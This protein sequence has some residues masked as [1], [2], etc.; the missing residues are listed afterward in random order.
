MRQPNYRLGWYIPNQVAGLTHIHADVTAEDF[1]AVV[2]AAQDLLQHVGDEFHI[3]ID[4]RV[5]AMSA[6]ASLAQMKQMAP[7]MNHPLLRWVVVIKPER[8]ALDTESL[9]I[10]RDGATQL[11]NVASLKEA[12]EHLRQATSG[13]QWQLVQWQLADEMFFH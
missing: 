6:P 9:P 4:N 3:L 7:F 13:V 2:Q 10:E 5:V 11:K 1:M 12:L 8:L